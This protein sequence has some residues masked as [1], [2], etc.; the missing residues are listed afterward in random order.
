LLAIILISLY[1]AS[2]VI[3]TAAAHGSHKRTLALRSDAKQWEQ[4]IGSVGSATT[5]AAIG[6]RRAH[7]FWLRRARAV[8]RVAADPPHK[9]GWLCIHQRE[10]SWS[11]TGDPYW[12]GLQMDRSFML[13]YAPA[14]L[15]RRG[16]ASAWTPL[17]QMWVAERAYRSGRGY[18]PWPNTARSCGLL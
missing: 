18:G 8:A 13:T 16:W 11:D 10:G 14:V 7:R 6:T 1:F 5:R 12:G 9:F 15:L 4:I 3:A 17:A 2:L